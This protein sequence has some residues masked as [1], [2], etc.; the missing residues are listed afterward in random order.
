MMILGTTILWTFVSRMSQARG[1]L[2]LLLLLLLLGTRRVRV[3]AARVTYIVYI[4][5]TA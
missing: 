4:Y 2:L 5:I 1:S 3:R